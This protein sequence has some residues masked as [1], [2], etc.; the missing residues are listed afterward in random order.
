MQEYG[1]L[2]VLLLAIWCVWVDGLAAVKARGP[3][4][5][6]VAGRCI[7]VWTE[8]SLYALRAF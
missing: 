2:Y 7:V 5:F 6:T 8:Q 3:D 1:V 4:V